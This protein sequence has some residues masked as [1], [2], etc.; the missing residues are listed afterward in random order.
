MGKAKQ[1]SYQK[2]FDFNNITKKA[3]ALQIQYALYSTW[4][5]ILY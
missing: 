1:A 3:K 2:H 4:N 5:R